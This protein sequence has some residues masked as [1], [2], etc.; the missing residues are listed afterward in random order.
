MIRP[1]RLHTY[2]HTSLLKNFLAL[3][4]IG[5]SALALA[6]WTLVGQDS[7]FDLYVDLS[8][9][10]RADN[11]VTMTY[12]YNYKKPQTTTEGQ[13]FHSGVYV[14]E[15][16]CSEARS[17]LKTFIWY[18]GQ[19]GRGNPT[20]LSRGAKGEKVFS[21]WTPATAVNIN[22]A[23]LKAAC[24]RDAE[25][26]KQPSAP[27][28]EG[29]V[30]LAGTDLPE[31]IKEAIIKC[32]LGEAKICFELGQAIDLTGT[33][34]QAKIDAMHFY[35]KACEGGNADGC[36]MLGASYLEGN[37]V[38]QDIPKAIQLYSKACDSGKA[39]ACA[40]LG[41]IYAKG[42]DVDRDSFRG[43]ELLIKA[44][45][46]GSSLGCFNAGIMVNNG[47]G[48]RLD[49]TKALE[50]FGKACDLKSE[51][52]CKNYATLKNRGH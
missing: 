42:I 49:K 1:Y 12:L 10:K 32:A 5:N 16:D 41:T 19:M 21:P 3:L 23:L 15:F 30:S 51:D 48:I 31:F 37:P 52:G 17:R 38:P 18:S 11:L 13:P 39:D 26:H 2:L 50:L 25:S 22:G 29:Q 9:I 24:S 8:T 40:D 6:D 35:T 4:L 28:F 27:N 14:A 20:Y 34:K 47:T 43:V 45:N 46:G 7:F 44:C 33:T 36:H